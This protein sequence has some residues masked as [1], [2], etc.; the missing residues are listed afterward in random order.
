MGV[1]GFPRT[2]ASLSQ[3]SWLSTMYVPRNS[4]RALL[5]QHVLSSSGVIYPTTTFGALAASSSAAAYTTAPTGN[6][7]LEIGVILGGIALLVLLSIIYG[8]TTRDVCSSKSLT[9]DRGEV[10]FFH[11]MATFQISHRFFPSS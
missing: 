7:V 3:L 9:D 8:L 5:R 4:Q 10:C 6:G 2:V 1:Y 11:Y